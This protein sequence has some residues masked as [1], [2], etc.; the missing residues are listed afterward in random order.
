[1]AKIIAIL[2]QA[3]CPKCGHK[4]S[5]KASDKYCY[6]SKCRKVFEKE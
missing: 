5:Y 3:I 4:F 6:C 2:K 1:M